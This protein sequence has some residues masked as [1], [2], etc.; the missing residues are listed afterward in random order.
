MRRYLVPV[1]LIATAGYL[2][3]VR[4]PTSVGFYSPDDSLVTNTTSVEAVPQKITILV[5]DELKA[6]QSLSDSGGDFVASYI[7]GVA[8][9]GLEDYDE[10]FRLWQISDSPSHT[11]QEVVDVLGSY[12]GNRCVSDFDMEWV[13]VEDEYGTDYAVRGKTIDVMAF[14]FSS[15]LKRIESQQYKFMLGIY[16]AVGESIESGRYRKRD[17]GESGQQTG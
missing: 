10:A 5:G 14:P 12:L 2:A 9:P 8:S 7:P 4:E 3:N 11:S 17:P 16:N 1:V 6:I 15:V 13:L